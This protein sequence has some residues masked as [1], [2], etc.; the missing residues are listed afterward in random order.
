MTTP[1]SASPPVTL[2]T[3]AG[4][5][6]GR[7]TAIALGARGHA[8]ALAG[9]RAKPLEDTAEAARDAGAHATA[10]FPTDLGDADDVKR[11]AQRTLDRFARVDHLVNNA[12]YV[13]SVPIER[14]SEGLL[15]RTFAV[16][17]F[18]PALLVAQ[19]W[20]TFVE[21]RDARIV[22][23]T[24]YA[25]I[26]PFPGFF[27][28]AQAKGAAMLQVKSIHNEGAEHNIRA[29]AVAPG[30]VETPMLRGLFNESVIPTTATLDPDTVAGVIVE[31]V[32]G[33]RDADS[34]ETIP[35]PNTPPSEEPAIE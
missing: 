12:G 20:S 11:L 19:L 4:S 10:I 9:R 13:E 32:T 17:A 29:F 30:A 14:T 5:G 23:V 35:L 28:Y 16:N 25:T 15:K 18:G 8:L 33:A 27:A 22:N 34:G 6:I 31:C 2:I 21:Q 24:S 1:P 26:D 7:S 3:G